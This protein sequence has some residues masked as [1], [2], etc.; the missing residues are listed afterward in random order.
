MNPINARRLKLLA[1][2]V[3][4]AAFVV[5]RF[6]FFLVE[7]TKYFNTHVRREEREIGS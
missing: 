4:E 1:A 5:D 7:N 6:F 3:N 2:C